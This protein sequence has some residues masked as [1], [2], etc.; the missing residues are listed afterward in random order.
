MTI[1]TKNKIIFFSHSI[2]DKN[3]VIGIK[4]VIR[5][6][7]SKSHK[8][9]VSS[10]GQSIRYGRNWIS[11]IEK[12]LINCDIMFAFVSNASIASPWLHYEVGYVASRNKPVIPV[13]INGFDISL[14]PFPIKIYQGFNFD[15]S[16]S[17]NKIIVLL[18]E[19][20][21]IK[22]IKKVTSQ[23]F[24]SLTRAIHNRNFDGF[25]R[26]SH[27]IERV[28]VQFA[29]QQIHPLEKYQEVFQ[30]LTLPFRTNRI[31]DVN[32]KLYEIDTYGIKF[33]KDDGFQGVFFEL[34]PRQIKNMVKIIL[35]MNKIGI[36]DEGIKYI[37]LKMDGSVSR[38][39]DNL[40]FLTKLKNTKVQFHDDKQLKYK[41]LIFTVYEGSLANGSSLE[42]NIYDL[43]SIKEINVI[44]ELVDYL[45]LKE[46]I[47]I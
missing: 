18:Q 2:Q 15:S 36:L 1:K 7:I 42:I 3:L 39:I 23:D 47:Y 29:K 40:I 24:Q 26:H 33:I 25:S 27:L 20:L 32:R 13:C 8:I 41:D 4:N 38:E 37:K 44:G 30:S 35:K 6:K 5:K 22:P 12:A 10:D 31:G 19:H 28:S 45:F 43:K 11:E 21:G 34:I 46:I 14:L 16:D 17:L 9:F